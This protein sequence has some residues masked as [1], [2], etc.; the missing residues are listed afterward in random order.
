MQP[1]GMQHAAC[2][3]CDSRSGCKDTR[4]ACECDAPTAA[5][6]LT[7]RQSDGHAEHEREQAFLRMGARLKELEHDGIN[8]L[9]KDGKYYDMET[10]ELIAYMK[11]GEFTLL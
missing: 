10:T 9:T 8:Y 6:L 11:N 3:H 2:N 4:N 1:R 5:A 7:Q